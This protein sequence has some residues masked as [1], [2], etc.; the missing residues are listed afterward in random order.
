MQFA[1]DKDDKRVWI[2]NTHSNQ[3]Y[4]CPY[5][6]TELITKKGDQRR[7]HF[8]HRSIQYCKDSWIRSNKYDESSWHYDWQNEFPEENREIKLELGQVQHRAD[9]IIDQT[10][11]EFQHSL[12]SEKDFYERNHFY[13][14]LG[15]K[16]IWLFDLSNLYEAK[17]NSF[18]AQQSC[19]IHS[20]KNPKEC[21]DAYDVETGTIELFFQINNSD[22][23]IVRVTH[24]SENGFEKFETTLLMTKEEFL[25]YVGMKNGDCKSPKIS[26]LADKGEYQ[27]FKEKY[28]AGAGNAE[29]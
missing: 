16:V 6:G 2:E 28:A 15:Y 7:H 17:R 18:V 10:V 8:A 29:H 19:L 24:V 1:V 4:F 9:V 13:F 25:D 3:A 5:C 23:S 27:E 26:A 22:K 21:F 12:L 14:N 20:W 11:I